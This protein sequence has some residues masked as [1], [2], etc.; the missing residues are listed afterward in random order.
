M[1]TEDVEKHIGQK[2]KILR[3]SHK[4]SQ[5]ALAEKRRLKTLNSCW[6]LKRLKMVITAIW[7]LK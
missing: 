6:R 7:L 4:M 1:N 2:I 5:K 3:I